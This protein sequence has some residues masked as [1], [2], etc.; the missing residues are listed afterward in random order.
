MKLAI[1]GSRN[2]NNYKVMKVFIFSKF[3]L[4]EIDTIV[5]G[6]ARGADTLA[7]KF[8]HENNL[9][10]IVKEAE[11]DKYGRSAGPRRN[12]LIVE[13]ADVVVAF[14]TPSSRGTWNTVNLAKEA[15]KRV[16]IL[17]VEDDSSSRR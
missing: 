1:V 9:L 15:G 8:A 13:E 12:K 7:E 17:H 4:S 2:F 10:L 5:S 6:G 11:W 14:P 16:E 3:D